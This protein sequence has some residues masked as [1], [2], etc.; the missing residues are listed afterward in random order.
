PSPGI[1]T[2]LTWPSFLAA[3][4]TWSQAAG[5]PA[6]E[7]DA[8]LVP[9]AGAG[10]AGAAALPQPVSAMSARTPSAVTCLAPRGRL[11]AL[12]VLQRFGIEAVLTAI[13]VAGELGRL[14]RFRFH[15]VQHG[16]LV[17]LVGE[18][19]VVAGVD[20]HQ[21]AGMEHDVLAF[22]DA[23]DVQLALHHVEEVLEA[24]MAVHFVAFARRVEVD[25]GCRVAVIGEADKGFAAGGLDVVG[26]ADYLPP[27]GVQLL[28]VLVVR[29]ALTFKAVVPEDV[30]RVQGVGAGGAHAACSS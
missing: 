18:L 13:A 2:K 3:A 21:L 29:A 12:A 20:V 22:V 24:R 15:L 23:V 10:L 28:P 30:A 1:V 9:T 4:S 11:C 17:G 8:P 26:N 19:V 16:E 25:D 14:G 5:E 7:A 6:A 27:L